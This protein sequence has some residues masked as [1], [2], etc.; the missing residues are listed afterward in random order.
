MD[1]CKSSLRMEKQKYSNTHNPTKLLLARIAD[2][3]IQ[4]LQTNLEKTEEIVGDSQQGTE[5]EDKYK[6]TAE[7][8]KEDLEETSDGSKMNKAALKIEKE[9]NKHCNI[10]LE[11]L[12]TERNYVLD[13]EEVCKNMF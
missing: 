7:E 3:F 10:L 9:E 2:Q 5:T 11:M 1:L 12:E 6:E 13:L 4:D 8:D